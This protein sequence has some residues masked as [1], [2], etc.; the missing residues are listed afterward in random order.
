VPAPT[1]QKGK[2]GQERE[3]RQ[4]EG[5]EASRTE[6]REGHPDSEIPSPRTPALHSPGSHARPPLLPPL[7]FLAS[8]PVPSLHR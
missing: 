3:R 7:R 1:K 8:S 4:P 2:R 6:Y 5:I